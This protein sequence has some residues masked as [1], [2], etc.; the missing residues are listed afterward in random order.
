MIGSLEQQW[1]LCTPKFIVK[2]FRGEPVLSIEGPVAAGIC[3]CCS[4]IDFT[5]TSLVNDAEVLTNNY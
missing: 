3:E 2:D 5:I 4:D 1:T